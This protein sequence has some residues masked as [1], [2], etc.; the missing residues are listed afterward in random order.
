MNLFYIPE[1]KTDQKQITFSEEESKHACRVLRM[2]IGD[3]LQILDGRGG[4]FDATIIND[5]P[6]HTVVSIDAFDFQE[7]PATEIHIAICPTKNMDRME[8]FLEKAT[9]LGVT[10][11]SFLL[12]SNSERKVL[13][14]DRLEKIAI[15]ALKQS[16]RKYIPKLNELVSVS[17]FLEKY[18][19]GAV[20]HCYPAE[21]KKLESVFKP[22][23]F[24]ILIGPEGDFSVAEVTQFTA[25][26]YAVIGL[27]ENRLRTETA[28]LYVCMQAVLIS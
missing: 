25:K 23:N 26:N 4:T 27:G 12:S 19:E 16:K 15:S 5:H 2:K 22:K 17:A 3:Q 8:W 24:P 10:E 9:E 1:I 28:G 7:A 20:A 6:K 21:K 14:L 18:P 11:V 13:K